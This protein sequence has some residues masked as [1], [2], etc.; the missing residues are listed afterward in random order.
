MTSSTLS[1]WQPSLSNSGMRK[2]CNKLI[3]NKCS[4]WRHT[5]RSVTQATDDRMTD[6]SEELRRR[7]ALHASQAGVR[8]SST[9][10]HAGGHVGR[11][12]TAGRRRA[13]QLGGY[14]PTYRSRE[15]DY[16]YQKQGR[17]T[18]M[19]L[20]LSDQTCRVKMRWRGQQGGS[21]WSSPLSATVSAWLLSSCADSFER[22]A[23]WKYLKRDDETKSSASRQCVWRGRFGWRGFRHG[24]APVSGTVWLSN[25]EAVPSRWHYSTTRV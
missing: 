22:S 18:A 14:A 4:R 24:E 6:D 10:L 15:E 5:F 13:I 8:P 19:F 11:N 3:I 20:T 7:R 17:A 16:L 23:D 12:P 1:A 25:I 2:R 9:V 21:C